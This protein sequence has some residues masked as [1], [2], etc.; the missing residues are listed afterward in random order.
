MKKS[1]SA[2]ADVCRVLGRLEVTV[3]LMSGV[4]LTECRV[5]R[6]PTSMITLTRSLVHQQSAVVFA[7]TFPTSSI[8]GSPLGALGF[9]LALGVAA[10]VP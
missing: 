5:L 4:R 2:F 6:S 9:Q 8:V 3:C 10:T 1:L 7:V